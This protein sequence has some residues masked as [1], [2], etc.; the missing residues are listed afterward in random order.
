[1]FTAT[2]QTNRRVTR[3]NLNQSLNQTN[4]LTNTSF[5]LASTP[6][7]ATNLNTTANLFNTN[8]RFKSAIQ[9]QANVAITPSTS[10]ARPVNPPVFTS[11]A[12]SHY[13]LL[14]D[15]NFSRV[16][17]HSFLPD[18]VLREL[19]QDD[20]ESFAYGRID[21]QQN[22]L[23]IIGNVLFVW[24]RDNSAQPCLIIELRN[25]EQIK[26]PETSAERVEILTSAATGL[27]SEVLFA[28]ESGGL[29][30]YEIP[31]NFVEISARTASNIQIS[32]LGRNECILLCTRYSSTNNSNLFILGTNLGR[33]FG[34]NIRG[35]TMEIIDSQAKAGLFT[36]LT[37]MFN[38]STA[39]SEQQ[40]SV[41]LRAIIP[42][43]NNCL[44]G[45][46]DDSV[47]LWRYT[48]NAQNQ[49]FTSQLPEIAE[50]LRS[51][52]EQLRFLHGNIAN[53]ELILLV[54]KQDTSEFYLFVYNIHTETTLIYSHFIQCNISL[55]GGNFPL[56]TY[57]FRVAIAETSMN[58]E[59][60]AYISCRKELFM[61]ETAIS[62]NF[63][64]CRVNF[65][66]KNILGSGICS[67]LTDQ[68]E[69]S[70]VCALL[71][72]D[73]GVVEAKFK[74][75]HAILTSKISENSDFPLSSINR[76]QIGEIQ[77]NSAE[78][79]GR[80][81]FSGSESKEGSVSEQLWTCF[82]LFFNG[83]TTAAQLKFNQITQNS[84]TSIDF[85]AISLDFARRIANSRHF[86]NN[87]R[88][89]SDLPSSNAY[90]QLLN[91][92]LAEKT[93]LYSAFLQFL[94]QN[95]LWHGPLTPSTQCKLAEI[96]EFLASVTAVRALVNE[97][98][99]DFSDSTDYI[100][101]R[102]STLLKLM[103]LAVESRGEAALLSSGLSYSDLFFSNITAVADLFTLIDQFEA[104]NCT[105]QATES[106]QAK[107]NKA[108]ATHS[109]N[110]IVF[111]VLTAA[112]QYREQ[113]GAIFPLKNSAFD[114]ETHWITA[115]T[116]KRYVL[117]HLEHVS[118]TI[119]A[120]ASV[121][122]AN[123]TQNSF[124][125]HLRSDLYQSL[126][127]VARCLLHS[128]AENQSIF[129]AADRNKAVSLLFS[130]LPA[131]L[132]TSIDCVYQF[133]AEFH[134]FNAI[135]ELTQQEAKQ[136][137]SKAKVSQRLN[138]YLVLFQQDFALEMF[139]F[140]FKRGW[141]GNLLQFQADPSVLQRYN[142][143]LSEY[144]MNF[145]QFAWIHAI[146][147]S[148]FAVAAQILQ[149][150]CSS[151]AKN[152]ELNIETYKSLLS[153]SKL[154]LLSTGISPSAASVQFL[155]DLLDCAEAQI[156]LDKRNSIQNGP[157]LDHKALILRLIELATKGNSQDSVAPFILSAEVAFKARF[158]PKNSSNP[159]ESP[160]LG[161]ILQFIYGQA[162]NLDISAWKSIEKG[163]SES[164]GGESWKGGY[165]QT[166][167]YQLQQHLAS[168]N[169]YDRQGVAEKSLQQTLNNAENLAP[170]LNNPT[171]KA[172]ILQANIIAAT[173]AHQ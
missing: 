158:G 50:T 3:A 70:E 45:V 146:N 165:K 71:C 43:A 156:Y 128:Y 15:D 54:F 73:Y 40:S 89:S 33:M 103:R 6:A 28:S 119:S 90:F 159:S 157:V 160:E 102:A 60:L 153:V 110:G 30:F 35:G 12:A 163:K 94:G 95:N 75:E 113:F 134:D 48:A 106:A 88:D 16:V 1:M 5:N 57:N 19:K 62:S 123:S 27:I 64:S 26:H 41:A 44:F 127:S 84:A 8:K 121:P 2:P 172:I 65:N 152:T 151:A 68:Q 39:P 85:N 55:S 46:K 104:E 150:I 147:R 56:E 61:V 51:S 133:A 24:N 87:S 11:S 7:H 86:L 117:V 132:G 81:D 53:N 170:E 36:G 142:A 149:E 47:V 42:W 129:Y 13:Q 59:P 66:G 23:I 173:E 37:R 96:G 72:A 112:A 80:Q 93:A 162:I 29:S 17:M 167:F 115:R 99:G 38:W 122:S 118:H 164:I 76:P 114:T 140:Y 34:L 107:R 154:S 74:G 63:L 144:L 91:N 49:L 77:R 125:S 108:L 135:L 148:D 120:L 67:G 124:F 78:T 143:W 79:R 166:V 145:P 98:Q 9:A 171:M 69:E 97:N 131:D 138:E 161:E 4:D 82:Q 116:S 83:Q 22:V 92:T 31:D 101:V 10:K 109:I 21:K 20:K 136:T 14:Q 169:Y 141:Q 139:N 32:A 155:N 130:A 137:T 18:V 126:H 111:T 105:I 100:E 52:K 168:Y 25:N 58:Q